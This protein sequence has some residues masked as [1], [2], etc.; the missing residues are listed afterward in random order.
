[1]K[2]T[3]TLDIFVLNNSDI[4]M[5][6]SILFRY[7]QIQIRPGRSALPQ[8]NFMSGNNIKPFREK[9]KQLSKNK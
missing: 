7:Q 4:S 6:L 8:I 1:M 9:I 2:W 3:C 5:I